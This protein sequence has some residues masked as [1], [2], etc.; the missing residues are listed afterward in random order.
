LRA[1][2]R[3]ALITLMPLVYD[4]LRVVARRQ[5][6]AWRGDLTLETT[7]LVHEAYLRLADQQR[8]NVDSRAHFLAVAAKTM[9][10]VL[11]NYSTHKRRKKRGGEAAHV[12]LEDDADGFNLLDLSEGDTTLLDAL[13]DAL[14][15]LEQVDRRLS[16]VVECRFFG[17]MSI[18]DTAAALDTSPATVKRHWA[19]ARSWLYREMKQLLPVT[20]SQ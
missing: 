12:T 9:R 11:C 20:D 16:D 4:E 14:V 17:G 2:D 15:K 1:G 13:D 7:A 10:H 3:E 6:R 5:R 8:I 19:L 18:D